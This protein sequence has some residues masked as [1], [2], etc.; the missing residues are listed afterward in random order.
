MVIVL[1]NPVKTKRKPE[2]LKILFNNDLV[3][4]VSIWFNLEYIINI[5]IIKKLLLE[6]FYMRLIK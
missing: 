3:N 2:K 4:S 6:R 5:Y 1:K